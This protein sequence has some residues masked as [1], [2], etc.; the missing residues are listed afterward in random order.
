MREALELLAGRLAATVRELAAFARRTRAIPALAYTHFQPA[1][2]TTVG[3]RACLWTQDF[4]MDLAE[5][6][7]RLATL[8][9][10]G[11]KGTTGTQASFLTLFQGDGAKDVS[12]AGDSRVGG[13]VQVTRGGGAAVEDSITEAGERDAVLLVRYPSRR[14]FSRMVAD[15]EYQEVTSLRTDA[16]EEAVLQATVPWS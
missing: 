7:H 6:R 15:P 16:L 9:C 2:L 3:K 10:R 12:V 11:V 1:Q 14:A 13:S 5:I 8:R 4:L